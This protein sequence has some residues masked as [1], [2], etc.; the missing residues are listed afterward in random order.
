MKKERYEWIQSWCDYADK[1]DLPRV[2]LVGDSITNG[3][4]KFVREKLSGDYYV[5]YFA[6]S[7]AADNPLY[8][9]AL[10][11][12]YKNSDYAAVHFNHGLHG[13]HMSCEEYKNNVEKTLKIFG[14]K[15]IIAESTAVYNQGNVDF[16][17]DWMARVN[18]RNRVLQEL[19]EKMHCPVN[20]LYALSLEM[21]KEKRWQDGV[22]YT[23][24]GYEVFAEKV[25]SAI[26][27][28]F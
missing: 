28:L 11:N 2:L 4:Q 6:T 12:F 1:T 16:N 22:H 24:E 19:A 3:Y 18:E 10:E 21:P 23:E 27:N 5:D 7:Y 15:L 8:T 25:A 20:A 26:K 9:V 17:E 14:C 13:V